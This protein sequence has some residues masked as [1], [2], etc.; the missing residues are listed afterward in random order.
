MSGFPCMCCLRLFGDA[1][2]SRYL[3]VGYPFR[4]V[5]WFKW[6]YVGCVLKSM[7]MRMLNVEISKESCWHILRHSVCQGG[8]GSPVLVPRDL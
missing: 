6:R 3:K 1:N 4:E 7:H 2:L 5:K 8:G